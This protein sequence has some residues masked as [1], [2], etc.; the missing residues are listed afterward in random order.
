MVGR[1]TRIISVGTTAVNVNDSTKPPVA[2][3]ILRYPSGG[4]TINMGRSNAVTASTGKRISPDTDFTDMDQ[5]S[6]CW[7]IASAGTISVEV[8]D[9]ES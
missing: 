2:F 6:N 1:E 3:R 7:C 9:Y 4:G 8:T 5:S